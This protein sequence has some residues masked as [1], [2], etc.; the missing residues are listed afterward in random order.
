M[1]IAVLGYAGSGKTYLS[2]FI[3]EKKSVPVLH[4]DKIKWDKEWK[5][6]DNS[7]VLPKVSEFMAKEDWIIDGYYD[8]LFYDERLEQADK[9]VLLLLPRFTCF[10]RVLKRAES[11][12]K[13]GYKN[14][15]NWWFVKFTLFGCRNKERRLSY[16]K[17]IEKYK[18]KTVVLKSKRQVDEFM[19]S[20]TDKKI[21]IERL[22]PEEY[23]KCFNIWNMNAQ[24]L[25]EKWYDE[26]V[27]GNRQVYIY[28][29]DGEFIGEGALVF[30]TGDADYTIPDKR[31][32]VSRMIV[33]KEYRNRG[34]GGEI[35]QFL[36]EKATEMGYTEMTVGVD[37]D[38]ENAVHLYKKYGFT[39][40]LFD[41]ADENGEYYKL[42]K[43]I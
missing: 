9:I 15:L 31:I 34:I 4:L 30:D 43:R 42:M 28:K 39:E 23:L 35:L 38:N 7:V 16:A 41:G 32:Y 6:I 24:P 13:D 25:A 18:E 11:R 21:T 5:Q 8:Y 20:F 40:V 17:I 14:D 26:I 27:S 1:K 22:K 33:K 2:D 19:E 10:Y 37:K 36:I 3:S 12:R 29:I